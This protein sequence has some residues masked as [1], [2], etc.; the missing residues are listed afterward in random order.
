ML[1]RRAEVVFCR[2]AA[3]SFLHERGISS[4]AEDHLHCCIVALLQIST[5]SCERRF[6]IM[7]VAQNIFT[8]PLQ[9]SS[10]DD[11]MINMSVSNSGY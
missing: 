9:A 6:G 1:S 2:S 11:L 5:A 10:V 7:T 4:A 3:Q 8:S